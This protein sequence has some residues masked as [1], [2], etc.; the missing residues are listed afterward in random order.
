MTQHHR[1]TS[2]QTPT[3]DTPTI[4]LPSG[5]RLACRSSGP[6]DGPLLLMLHGFPQAAFVW[7][8]LLVHLGAQGYRCVAPNLRGYIGSSAPPE[9]SAYKAGAISQD[10]VDL[11][12]HLSPQRPLAALIAHDWGGAI[13][14]NLAATQGPQRLR[15]LIAIN[16]PHPATFLHALQHDAEQQQASSYMHFLARD[17]AADLLAEGDFARLWPFLRDADHPDQDPAWL[18]PAL[19][20]AHH[21]AWSAGLRGPCAYYQQSPLK[22]SRGADDP[23]MAL[24]LPKTLTEVNVPTDV[25]WGDGD[26]ALRPVLLD[27]LHEHVHDLRIHHVA[28]ASHW[29]IHEQ[30]D[31]VMRLV[32]QALQRNSA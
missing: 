23:V 26:R 18:S 32:T 9:A 25:I 31:T 4:E 24:T 30:P 19:K 15:Q 13:A 1:M 7:D 11:M 10:I 14:W 16:S 29:V 17:D 3:I 2:P 8:D 6:E 27:G 12:H 28:D 20:Q 5:I 21:D 22:P